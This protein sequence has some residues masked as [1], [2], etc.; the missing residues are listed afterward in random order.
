VES[1]LKTDF[2]ILLVEDNADARN[3]MVALLESCG[4][5]VFAAPDVKTAVELSD[6]HDFNLLVA[7]SELPDGTGAELF[8]KLQKTSPDLKAIAVSGYGLPHDVSASHAAGFLAHLLKPVNFADLKNAIQ[9]LRV[10][11]N[12]PNHYSRRSAVRLTAP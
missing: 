4:Y 7:D 9:S 2:R 1:A 10:A 6:W 11:A 8:L 5:E 3:C 12:E